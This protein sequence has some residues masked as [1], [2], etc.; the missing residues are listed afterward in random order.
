MRTFKTV[1]SVESFRKFFI[2]YCSVH[3]TVMGNFFLSSS[4]VFEEL[5][6]GG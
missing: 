1:G 6:S 5:P 4:R 2:D 3:Y